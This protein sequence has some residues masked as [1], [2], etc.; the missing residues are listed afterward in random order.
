MY[1]IW[2]YCRDIFFDASLKEL[3]I[4]SVEFLSVNSCY[5]SELEA[6]SL[7]DDTTPLTEGV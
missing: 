5:N 2:E 4:F 1:I 7:L 3:V 6:P